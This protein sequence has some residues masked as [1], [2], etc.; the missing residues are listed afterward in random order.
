ME[1]I[2]S[3]W[4]I[5]SLSIVGNLWRLCAF[6]AGVSLAVAFVIR[7]EIG[8][9]YDERSL[10]KYNRWLKISIALGIIFG[11]LAFFLPTRETYIAMI[12]A[13]YATTDNIQAVQGNII[14]FIAKL[15]EAASQY[16]K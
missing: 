15:T 9:T 11:L 2:I 12:A 16:M 1:P 7:I 10:E 14:D 8:D 3:P 4:L 13:S 6:V 5:Y